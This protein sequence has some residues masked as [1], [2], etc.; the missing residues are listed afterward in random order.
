M[1]T[2]DPKEPVPAIIIR[3]TFQT[4]PNPQ[5]LRRTMGFWSI[6]IDAPAA[7]AAYQLQRT[8]ERYVEPISDDEAAAFGV[9]SV[10]ITA[11]PESAPGEDR[12]MTEE[13]FGIDDDHDV[14]TVSGLNA[15]TQRQPSGPRTVAAPR[16]GVRRR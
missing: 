11:S 14:R 15:P 6:P 5:P 1:S 2:E 10:V 4:P 12:S 9:P 16:L 3:R 7:Q 13:R 8:I